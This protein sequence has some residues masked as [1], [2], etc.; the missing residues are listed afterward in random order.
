MY[1]VRIPMVV[2]VTAKVDAEDEET[3][4]DKALDIGA[5]NNYVGNG[6][7][8]KLVGVADR[9]ASVSFDPEPIECEMY[10]RYVCI[11]VDEF[12]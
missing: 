1:E 12:I 3:A 7:T 10:G 9:A 11:E 8:D 6:G 4:I 5:L 2:W